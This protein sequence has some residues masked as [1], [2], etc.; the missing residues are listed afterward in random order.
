MIPRERKKD[1]E[2]NM[3]SEED[4]RKEREENEKAVEALKE[5][6]KAEKEKRVAA[7]KKR[8]AVEKKRID[9]EEALRMQ[10]ESQP[11]KFVFVCLFV[12]LFV[13]MLYVCMY[14]CL[15]QLNQ[16]LDVILISLGM[17]FLVLL[18]HS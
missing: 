8:K 6:L 18:F 5:T 16:S 17:P 7:E 12:C 14:V 13:C 11:G 9:L 15:C 2:E 1:F 3:A 10:Q 4:L